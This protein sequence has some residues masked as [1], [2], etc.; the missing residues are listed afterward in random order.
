MEELL[1]PLLGGDDRHAFNQLLLKCKVLMDER[2]GHASFPNA[3]RDALD[4]V[5]A[6]IAC[7][8]YSR[9][10]CFEQK[11]RTRF[12]PVGYVTACKNESFAVALKSL[13]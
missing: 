9:H 6:N 7:A 10:T 3:T 4:R 5:M 1:L 8:E 2:D 11:W 13:R 12:F